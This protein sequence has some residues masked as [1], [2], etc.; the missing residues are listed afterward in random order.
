M[1]ILTFKAEQ[2]EMSIFFFL[3]SLKIH[4]RVPV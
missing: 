3:I 2:A 4:F 1:E